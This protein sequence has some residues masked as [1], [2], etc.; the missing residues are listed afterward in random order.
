MVELLSKECFP[1]F[2]HNPDYAFFDNA[3]TTQIHQT[4]LDAM[5][6][7]YTTYR[8]SPGRGEYRIADQADRAVQTSREKVAEMLNADADNILFTTGATQGLNWVSMWERNAPTVC[9]SNM[10][11]NANIV[12][13]LA[14]GRTELKGLNVLYLESDG[15]INPDHAKKV[16]DKSKGGILSLSIR[17]N[18]T[19]VETDWEIITSLA[20]HRGMKVCLDASQDVFSA[21]TAIEMGA[22]DY[23]VFSGHKMFGPS[24]VG[25]LYC[26]QA[27]EHK[28]VYAGGGMV[29]DVAY[30]GF[31][32]NTDISRHQAGTPNT[33]SIIGMGAAAELISWYGDYYGTDLAKINFML[34]DAG[35][36]DIP[37]LQLLGDK[38][39]KHRTVYS[40]I[41]QSVDV[42]DICAIL[43]SNEVA[44]RSGHMC[45]Y[46]YS[47]QLASG[48]S[49]MRISVA[50]YNTE[51]DCIKLVTGINS[52]I[53]TL[54]GEN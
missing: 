50:P 5:N 47:K 26:A 45:A 25:V 15:G 20:K 1:F 39:N 16:L 6:E 10:E 46:P 23:L 29:S 53:Q 14:Q 35:L 34:H 48:K 17:S 43:N 42:S 33:P 12:P 41:G 30:D 18:L 54:K 7:Y 51:L 31:T 28:P 9:I 8:A 21:R 37:E 3:S 49:I 11:H 40:F 2:T 36:F 27:L 38:N 32:L 19:G 4:V 13:W 44:V 24:G 22:V 52:A